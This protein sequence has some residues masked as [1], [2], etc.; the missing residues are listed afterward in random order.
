MSII[1]EENQF[2]WKLGLVIS[3]MLLLIW[4]VYIIL[5]WNVG[6][7][8]KLSDNQAAFAT[9]TQDNN[10]IIYYS[11]TD[12]AIDELDIASKQNKVIKVLKIGTIYDI[13]WAPDNDEAI[14]RTNS[15]DPEKDKY[16]YLS[17]S[18][19]ILKPYADN[20]SGVSW[21]GTGKLISYLTPNINNET[22]L[23]EA[24]PDGSGAKQIYNFHDD[25]S[26]NDNSFIWSKDD[27]F[28][29]ISVGPTDMGAAD[30]YILNV[31]T[32]AKSNLSTRDVAN[33]G[34]WSPNS[35]KII[36]QIYNGSD[37]DY[38]LATKDPSKPENKETSLN[39]QGQVFWLSDSKT[40][41][42]YNP[43]SV[44]KI[45]SQNGSKN[46]I[47]QPKIKEKMSLDYLIKYDEIQKKLYFI[48]NGILY[49]VLLK[50]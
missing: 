5:N 42:G 29:A 44:W 35:Q 20:V 14:I 13:L 31:Q 16:W 41:M 40:L 46:N 48:S 28:I 36:F 21:S 37:Q 11:I 1:N 6:K 33:I 34:E 8:V 38:T 27:Q 15:A 7:A 39:F 26:Q 17:L 10:K 3:A 49:K 50:K 32:G 30:V 25:I 2:Y 22:T 43:E 19:N 4:I 47:Y 9:I 23:S 45:N 24:R 12:Q 18:K